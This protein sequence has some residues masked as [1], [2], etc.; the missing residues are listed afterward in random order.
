M[1]TRNS[2]PLTLDVFSKEALLHL[3]VKSENCQL[4]DSNEHQNKYSKFNWL[5]G[6]GKIAE[7]SSSVNSFAKLRAFQQ[8][9]QDWLLGH[10][11]YSLK[12]EVENLTSRNIDKLN[13]PNLAFFV[14]ETIIIKQANQ[15][16]CHSYHYQNEKELA[17]DLRPLQL[18]PNTPPHPKF[19]ASLKKEEYLNHIASL[20][21]EL[22][23]GNIYEINFCQAWYAQEA[24][25]PLELFL[26]LNRKH[27]APFA[28]FY[29]LND[30]Y[31]LCF[32]PE[33]YLQKT[34]TS[35]I[36]QPIKG[37]APRSANISLD[38]QRKSGLLASEK[39][40]AENVMIVDLVRN[41]LSRTAAKASVQVEE[42]FGLYSFK[43]VHQM[44]STISSTLSSQYDLSDVLKT[45]FPM[46][47]MT[48]APKISAMQ[49]I[50]E[51]ENFNR[52]LYSG[53]VGY[54]N[55]QGDADFNVII[56]SILYSSILEQAEVK[57]GGAITIHCQ[58]EEEY[59][60][61]LLKAEK[62]IAASN[63]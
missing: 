51:H 3:A 57:V 55:P 15:F 12:D 28:S 4:L 61:C 60:E 40:R 19:T 38:Q 63:D 21:E 62:V 32:S 35:L 7:L 27:K 8:A 23:A 29:R 18:E 49:L 34:G 2:F 22:Q 52:G 25:N 44:I 5:L 47:S 16:T 17:A 20:K 59:Q 45:T 30:K 9:H 31:L 11:A 48:G 42:L 54:I 58:A 41:D 14:P 26:E 39:E 36:S 43:A 37:T 56:R 33:R 10:L 13:W 53:S 46:G 6:W 24:I 1:P 50:D